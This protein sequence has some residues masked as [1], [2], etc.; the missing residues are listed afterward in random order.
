MSKGLSRQQL[1]LLGLAVAVSRLRHRKP[2]AHVPMLDRDGKTLV[3][4]GAQPDLTTALAAHV[5]GGCGLQPR[6][7]GWPRYMLE[8][9]PVAMNRR[10]SISRA[11][12]SLRRRGLVA[13]KPDGPIDI[14]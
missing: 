11:I 12:S 10:S 4:K 13:Y 2:R 5:V 1:R 14:C 3:V 8:A 6:L 7:R 9:T